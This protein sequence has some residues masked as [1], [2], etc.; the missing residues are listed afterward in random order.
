MGS[1]CYA[2]PWCCL[3]LISLKCCSVG[4][5]DIERDRYRK[6]IKVHVHQVSLNWRIAYVNS[7]VL[8]FVC[9]FVVPPLAWFGCDFDVLFVQI[10]ELNLLWCVSLFLYFSS[11]YVLLVTSRL[12][13]SFTR[14]AREKNLSLAHLYSMPC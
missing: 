12:F 11:S 4:D 3:C 10:F 2:S 14:L 6:Q 8:A 5:G 9:L 13:V 7:P 1:L